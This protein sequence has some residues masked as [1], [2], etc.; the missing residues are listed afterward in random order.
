MYIKL[1]LANTELFSLKT[2]SRN[3]PK[4]KTD[5]HIN[6]EIK[7]KCCR[8]KSCGSIFVFGSDFHPCY[9]TAFE[10]QGV[11][12]STVWWS[13]GAQGW[14]PLRSSGFAFKCRF[15]IIQRD[16]VNAQRLLAGVDDEGKVVVI[17]IDGMNKDIQTPKIVSRAS[18][19][20]VE[21]AI[22]YGTET[23]VAIVL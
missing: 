3:T 11:R 1:I 22:S 4:Q 8:R 2:L 12:L 20:R 10:K 5:I 13:R 23:T 19:L 16:I 7:Q 17:Q 21:F 9:K 18:I 15:Y 14:T 6:S